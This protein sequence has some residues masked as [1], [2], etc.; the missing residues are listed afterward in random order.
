MKFDSAKL[1]RKILVDGRTESYVDWALGLPSG[2]VKEWAKGNC[3][4][5]EDRALLRIIAA[6]PWMI[7]VA[8]DKFDPKT[9][10]RLLGKACDKAWKSLSKM[11]SIPQP[12]LRKKG[13]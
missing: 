12:K 9:A 6:W 1:V 10:T 7:E 2:T 3:V 8:A 13:S 5:A 11:V 4:S